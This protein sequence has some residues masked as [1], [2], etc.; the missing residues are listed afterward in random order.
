MLLDSVPSCRLN[1]TSCA[2]KLPKPQSEEAT[3]ALPQTLVRIPTEHAPNLQ[4]HTDAV[5]AGE[6]EEQQQQQGDATQ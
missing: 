4:A 3:I 1:L 2:A 5:A 6:E